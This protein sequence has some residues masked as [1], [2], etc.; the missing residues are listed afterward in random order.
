MTTTHRNQRGFT[1][2]E[3]LIA[4]VLLAFG[5]LTL[6]RGMGRASQAG[7][8]AF[9]RAQ[10]MAL[11]QEMSDRMNDN[12]R[13]A[14][15]YVGDYVPGRTA[16]DCTGLPTLVARDACEWRNRLLGVDTLDNG[17]TIG[18][19]MAARGCV[20]SPAPNVYVVTVAWQGVLATAAPDSACGLNAFDQEANRR[21]FSTVLQVATLGV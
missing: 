15:Q 10:A 19:P 4:L 11:A 12:L 9:Q 5:M 3:L 14:A 2:I 8:E 7:L 1:L 21:V 6:A 18:A 17:S 13:Q 20:I 16:E